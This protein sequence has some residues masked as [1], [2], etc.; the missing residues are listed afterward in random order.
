MTGQLTID[1]VT[2][3]RRAWRHDDAQRLIEEEL[4][5]AAAD[6]PPKR[7]DQWSPRN[8]SLRRRG[9]SRVGADRAM[10]IVLVPA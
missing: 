5:V 4:S 1:R 9:C 7:A 2:A 3:L 10:A 6:C 8:S